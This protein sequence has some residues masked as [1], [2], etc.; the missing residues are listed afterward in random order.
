M[1]NNTKAINKLWSA[2][3]YEFEGVEYFVNK[4]VHHKSGY[5]VIVPTPLKNH[6]FYGFKKRHQ[7]HRLTR[8]NIKMLKKGLQVQ[9]LYGDFDHGNKNEEYYF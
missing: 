8:R 7:T 4:L 9:H 1:T 2:K 6:Y 5:L 3:R